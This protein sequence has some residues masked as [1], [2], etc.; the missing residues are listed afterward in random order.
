MGTGVNAAVRQ[1]DVWQRTN[2]G[3][4]VFVEL[5]FDMPDEGRMVTWGEIGS[6]RENTCTEAHFVRAY[7][8]LE[9]AE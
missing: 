7:T 2:D 5:V 6:D 3:T 9:R 1:Y 4:E 8:I